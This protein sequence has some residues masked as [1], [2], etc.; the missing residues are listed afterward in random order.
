MITEE[1]LNMLCKTFGKQIFPFCIVDPK[2]SLN[3]SADSECAV[4]GKPGIVIIEMTTSTLKTF[5]HPPL[6]L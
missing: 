3:A 4:K 5:E 2:L 1:G 6:A